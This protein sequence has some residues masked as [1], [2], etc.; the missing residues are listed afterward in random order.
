[1]RDL[2]RECFWTKQKK[3][4]KKV[5]KQKE[6]KKLRSEKKLKKSLKGICVAHFRLMVGFVPAK[7]S[8]NSNIGP[9]N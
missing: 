5:K 4:K 1:M 3:T 8:R 7:R 6:K 9:S 2:T